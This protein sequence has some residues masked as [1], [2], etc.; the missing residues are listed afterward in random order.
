M[1]EDPLFDRYVISSPSL[2]WDDHALL[3]QRSVPQAPAYSRSV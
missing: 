1:A 2:W 3:R